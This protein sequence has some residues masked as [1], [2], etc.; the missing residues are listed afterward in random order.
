MPFWFEKVFLQSYFLNAPSSQSTMALFRDT[1]SFLFFFMTSNSIESDLRRPQYAPAKE[2]LYLRMK[3]FSFLETRGA[4]VTK[5]HIGYSYSK[6][7]KAVTYWIES[8]P[9]SNKPLLDLGAGLGFQTAAAIKAGRDVAAVDID[10]RNLQA[11]R[12]RVNT[13]IN[14]SSNASTVPPGNVVSTTE[15]CLP[16]SGLFG[17][18]SAAGILVSEMLHFL[19][20]GESTQLFRD[21]FSWLQPGGRLVVTA[22]S[23][24]V[25]D[26][27]G[28][29][30]GTLIGN[31]TLEETWDFIYSASDEQLAKEALFSVEMPKK[32]K[33]LSDAVSKVI[34]FIS[35]NE[36][37]AYANLANFEIEFLDYTSPKKCPFALSETDDISC[38]VARKPI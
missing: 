3:D 30:G 31:R 17:K 34:K 37:F 33:K 23:P 28:E 32:E 15:A 4:Y 2:P 18:E 10:K 22:G 19:K 26:A 7:D 9:E 1:S 6:L 35:T 16:N 24:V 13:S 38:L 20:L 8:L 5:N 25:V 36:L 14:N 21:A 29:L 11:L 27:L 12:E